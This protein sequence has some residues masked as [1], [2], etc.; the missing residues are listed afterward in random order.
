MCLLYR[1]RV[2]RCICCVCIIQVT[3]IFCV[4]M[5]YTGCV[6]CMCI[7]SVCYTGCVYTGVVGADP[8]ERTGGIGGG[9]ESGSGMRESF[10]LP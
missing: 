8:L 3:C 6:Y 9:S 10:T 2:Y 7:C 5:C 1:L 4:F